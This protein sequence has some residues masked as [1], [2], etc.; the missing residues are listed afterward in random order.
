M[1]TPPRERALEVRRTA[2]Y[3]ELGGDGGR[4]P[5]EL[6]YVL[7]GYGQLASELAAGLAFLATPERRLV[8]P[9]GL[10]R[11]YR[12]GTGGIVGASWMTKVAREAEIEDYVDYLDALHARVTAD[13]GAQVR[14]TVLGFSQGT[15]TAS[16]WVARGGVRAE[17]VILW[18]GGLPPDVDLAEARAA[19]RGLS[20]AAGERDAFITPER[21]SEERARV[22]AAGLPFRLA[23]FAGGHRLDDDLLRSLAGS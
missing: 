21:L 16:R 11:F 20:F 19:F 17:R 2:R 1:P 7:H 6:W 10:S 9:E 15:A 23:T 3:F 8:V 5:A 13:L 14:A 4:P 18:G 12:D 22:E